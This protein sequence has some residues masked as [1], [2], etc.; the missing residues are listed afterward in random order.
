MLE[1]NPSLT[2]NAVKAI[3][4]FTAER[5]PDES[6]LAQGAGLINVHGAIRMAGFFG[7]PAPEMGLPGDTIENEW[8][9]WSEELL[10]GNY[11]ITGGILLPRMNAWAPGVTWGTL[12]T[13]AGKPVVWGARD[14]DNIVWST[15]GRGNDNIVWSTSGRGNDNI[16]WSTGGRGDDNI[17]WSTGGRD[18]DNIVWSTSGRGND[19]IVWSTAAVATT[20]SSGAPR[21]W[22]RQHRLE[23]RRP[24]QRQHRLE[25]RWT[26][27][28]Q[29][30]LEHRRP[31]HR[32]HRLE[33][34]RR[35]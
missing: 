35:Q 14:A 28:R 31:R 11:M 33:Y 20:T 17:V 30:R 23:H 24:R 13:T 21:P 27:Q 10:W 32:E 9:P 19:N 18:N 16:V 22:Q 25:H 5:R 1:V 4:E 3:L 6:T 2:P 29:H 8:V 26:R 7:H 12:Q 34:G 15:S